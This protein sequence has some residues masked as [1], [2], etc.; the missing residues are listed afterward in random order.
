MDRCLEFQH[1][2][3]AMLT[4]FMLCKNI[5]YPQ[6]QHERL[7]LRKWGGFTFYAGRIWL[8]NHTSMGSAHVQLSNICAFG[9]LKLW[10]NSFDLKRFPQPMEP[11][12]S[13]KN[14]TKK[15]NSALQRLSRV[16]L[17]KRPREIKNTE[18]EHSLPLCSSVQSLPSSYICLL[19]FWLAVHA[20]HGPTVTNHLMT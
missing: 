13:K 11:E 12:I 4:Y 19:N 5:G 14:E 10:R 7:W 17:G 9:Y 6:C 15:K 18:V 3:M 8:V 16:I 1:S 20:T 2:K